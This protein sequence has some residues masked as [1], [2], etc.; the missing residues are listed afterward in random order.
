MPIFMHI[1]FQPTSVSLLLLLKLGWKQLQQTYSTDVSRSVQI[2]A[3]KHVHRRIL[4]LRINTLASLIISFHADTHC[5]RVIQSKCA[6]KFGNKHVWKLLV[7]HLYPS[8]NPTDFLIVSNLHV[9]P[10]QSAEKNLR[11]GQIWLEAFGIPMWSRKEG[12]VWRTLSLC[13]RVLIQSGRQSP[14]VRLPQ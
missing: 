10:S 11:G 13:A 1:Y 4:Q 5:I 14:G 2:N 8:V 12:R 6:S 7:G 9:K 3:C